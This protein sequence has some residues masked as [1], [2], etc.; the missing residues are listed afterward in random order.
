MGQPEPELTHS[1]THTHGW[2]SKLR[3]PFGSPKCW[4]P[5]YTKDPK[6]DRNFDNHPHEFHVCGA[7]GRFQQP[8]LQVVSRCWW[9][10]LAI[11]YRVPSLHQEVRP[12]KPQGQS[13]R[14]LKSSSHKKR[15]SLLGNLHSSSRCNSLAM[16]TCGACPEGKGHG[17]AD[18]LFLPRT[19]RQRT[20]T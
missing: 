19:R 3:S 15:I 11:S 5:Y 10:T 16:P 12:P 13:P 20:R 9:H 6:K 2:L 7:R 4:V 1:L 14:S 18:R 17:R 8:P